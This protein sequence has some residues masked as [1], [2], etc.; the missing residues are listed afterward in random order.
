M[1]KGAWRKIAALLL[2]MALFL[3]CGSEAAWA[4]T[5]ADGT[6]LESSGV[7]ETDIKKNGTQDIDRRKNSQQEDVTLNNSSGKAAADNEEDGEDALEEEHSLVK[8]ERREA[9]CAEEGNI[10]YFICGTCGKIFLDEAG[11]QEIT[12]QKEIVLPKL[13]EHKWDGGKITKKASCT[14]EGI[15]TYSCNVC[16]INKTEKIPAAGHRYQDKLTRATTKKQ[17]K[18]VTRCTVCGKVNKQTVISRIKKITLSGTS[19]TYNGKM[20]A[21]RAKVVDA[22]GKKISA[23]YYV[24]KNGKAKNVGTHAVKISF[25]GRYKGSVTRKFIIKPKKV[26]NIKVTPEKKGFTVKYKKQTKQCSGYQLQ[27]A[28]NPKFSGAVRIT[29]KRGVSQKTV[30]NLDNSTTYYVR[31]RTFKKV[32]E[33][34]KVKTYYSA[35]S[36]K[37]KVKTEDVKLICID[38]GHQQRGDSSL[39]PIG[40]GASSQKA[41]VASGASGAATGRPEYQLTLEVALKLQEEL[42]R[43]GYDVLMVRT[44]HDVNISNSARAAIANNARA[45]AFIRIHANSSTNASVNGAI[46]ICQTPANVYCGAYYSQS[47]RLSEQ[48][49]ANFVAA[50]GCKNGGIWE[51]DT[52]S[53]INWCSVPVTILEMGYMSNPS[54]DRKMSDSAYQARMVQGIANGVDA[55]FAP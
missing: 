16:K 24:V 53:G 47:R 31:M 49:L 10:E 22:K 11:T 51:T 37:K 36:K 3:S 4:G 45:D 20:H 19:Y 23:K 8:T 7:E 52:M 29:L 14:K 43:R 2:G 48:I 55:Y 17:G 39:E 44:T 32:K 27:Y 50:C 25:R 1:E 18:I 30:E 40:P 13:S 5:I 9:T 26:T 15:L 34:G 28:K 54:E 12:E 46:T 38:A 35:W 6:L 21:P 33:H 42:T 41:K